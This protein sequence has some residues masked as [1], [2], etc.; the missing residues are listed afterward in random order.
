MH[1]LLSYQ[2]YSDF[3]VRS[4]KLVQYTFQDVYHFLI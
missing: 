1:S 2:A 4:L 3:I